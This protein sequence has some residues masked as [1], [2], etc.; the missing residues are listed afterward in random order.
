MVDRVA[1]LSQHAA[2]FSGLLQRLA[3]ISWLNFFPLFFFLMVLLN[4]CILN[5]VI[6]NGGNICFSPSEDNGWME[7][8]R[9]N[10]SCVSVWLCTSRKGYLHVLRVTN[11][12]MTASS[13]PV[14][15]QGHVN[16]GTWCACF[17]IYLCWL[18]VK[19]LNVNISAFTLWCVSS[20]GMSTGSLLPL[21]VPQ[22][23]SAHLSS[24]RPLLAALGYRA[25]FKSIQEKEANDNFAI[26]LL[27]LLM[28]LLL[29]L[30]PLS[31]AALKLQK[32]FPHLGYSPDNGFCSL[33]TFLCH[34]PSE[35]E[36]ER[37]RERKC[38]FEPEPCFSAMT[39]P[40]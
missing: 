9:K 35:R 28:L 7:K 1:E 30:Y 3:E 18:S 22:F 6:W 12:V 2:G 37:E 10:L 20:A 34:R 24:S 17:L 26:L 8:S 39:F 33:L 29:L 27:G 21:F 31:F 16:A 23:P 4:C 11:A 32:L 25:V 19:F 15:N 40:H 36:T 13:A 14:R 38:V 5:C